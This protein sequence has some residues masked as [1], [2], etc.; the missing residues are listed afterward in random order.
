MFLFCFFVVYFSCS[1]SIFVCLYHGHLCCP[2]MNWLFGLMRFSQP[3]THK[4]SR[5]CWSDN[6]QKTRQERVLT[7]CY[8]EECLP[9][10]FGQS[11]SVC[12]LCVCVC[13]RVCVHAQT[14]PDE[15]VSAVREELKYWQK[16]RH[17]LER[18]RLLVELIR[19]RE[20]LKREQ[21]LSGFAKKKRCD[22]A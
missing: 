8:Y 6:L 21:V 16:L 3:A 7:F 5:E 18:A 1:V 9:P 10:C 14:E 4:K 11:Y 22:A 2:C 13:A 19:K 17:D 15:K 20:K 12:L